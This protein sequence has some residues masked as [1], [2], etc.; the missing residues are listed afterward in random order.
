MTYS[1]KTQRFVQLLFLIF[2]VWAM[3]TNRDYPILYFFLILFSI[4]I[5]ATLFVNYV[6]KIG[7]D[8]LTFRILI[9]K[10]TVYEKD[11]HHKQID[12]IK[13][14]RVGWG[15]KRAIVKNYKGF[16]FHISKFYPEEIYNDLIDF[17]SQYN[18]P[19]SKTK[20]YQILEKMK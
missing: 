17:A 7:K 14:K 2:A 12:S 19:I 15:E 20:D 9:F 1:A 11:V 13:F 5:L 3:F 4:F 18:I 8:S 16:N 6:F 10:F